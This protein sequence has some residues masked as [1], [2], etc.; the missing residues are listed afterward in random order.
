MYEGI[1]GAL[2]GDLKS[3]Y[4][5]GFTAC[6][7]DPFAQ[8]VD[9]T[10]AFFYIAGDK[11]GGIFKGAIS[12]NYYPGDYTWNAS[13]SLDWVELN[14]VDLTVP[15][16]VTEIYD[17]PR[18]IF[19]VENSGSGNFYDAGS[20]IV[21]AFQIYKSDGIFDSIQEEQH[22][23]FWQNHI[24]ANYT[25]LAGKTLVDDCKD[26]FLEWE[27]EGWEIGPG[28]IDNLRLYM[29]AKG[30]IPH[31]RN[32]EG[33]VAGGWVDIEYAVTGIA[34]GEL[35]G[36]Y[37]PCDLEIFAGSGGVW[38]STSILMD[39]LT[40]D[41]GRNDLAKLNIPNVTIGKATL[42]GSYVDGGNDIDVTMTDVTFLANA[43]GGIPR[44][45]ATNN[46]SGTYTG[47]P[48]AGWTV[49][50][51]FTGSSDSKATAATA[52]F[53]LQTW[54]SGKWDATVT[55][56]VGTVN[57]KSISFKG[58]AAGSIDSG[59]EFSGTAAGWAKEN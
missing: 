12:G 21:G 50:L 36:G 57:S 17:Y 4:F 26:W 18:D 19:I 24:G 30:T 37:D 35:H 23:G 27:Q 45:W 3:G 34:V 9:G 1:R 15:D 22:W 2:T 49:P 20:D 48:V 11:S 42:E 53:N 14:E 7:W 56:G 58:G 59:T 43:S 5:F 16:S 28:G 25:T 39:K 40:T 55:N 47:T 29:S 13:G 8:T 54:V 33:D 44:I 52:N 51:G 10:A 46:V 31:Y 38:I 6:G 32:I 41:P